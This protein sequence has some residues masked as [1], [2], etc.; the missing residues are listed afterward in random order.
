MICRF[1]FK[2]KKKSMNKFVFVAAALILVAGTVVQGRSVRIPRQ[3][4]PPGNN[5]I[6]RSDASAM[7]YQYRGSELQLD[8]CERQNYRLIKEYRNLKEL[9]KALASEKT[10]P[11][12]SEKAEPFASEE[13]DMVSR[14]EQAEKGQLVT[15]VVKLLEKLRM[16]TA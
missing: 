14:L 7:D 4:P 10:E 1:L 12:A 8:V 2:V 11:L 13:A 16:E 5:Y 3:R 15:K 6:P 9:Y